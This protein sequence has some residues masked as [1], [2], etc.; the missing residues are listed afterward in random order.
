L[1]NSSSRNFDFGSRCS[2]NPLSV[3]FPLRFP[4]SARTFQDCFNCSLSCTLLISAFLNVENFQEILGF[5]RPIR[6]CPPNDHLKIQ[7]FLT[8]RSRGSNDR[9]SFTTIRNP[10]TFARLTVRFSYSLASR[11]SID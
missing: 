10:T 8:T 9:R 5:L 11:G 7:Y 3:L 2:L 6:L 1:S 4:S